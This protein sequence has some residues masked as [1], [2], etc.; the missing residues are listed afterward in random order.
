VWRESRSTWHIY[1]GGCRR[2]STTSGR[3]FMNLPN[4][5]T[6]V[7]EVLWRR[8]RGEARPA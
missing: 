2:R 4:K 1:A 8:F 3:R 7:D 5:T 6:N